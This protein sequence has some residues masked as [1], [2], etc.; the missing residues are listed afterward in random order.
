[1]QSQIQNHLLAL[2]ARNYSP[3]TVWNRRSS[4]GKF[5]VWSRAAGLREPAE[6][7]PDHLEAYRLSLFRAT[8][9]LGKLLGWGTQAEYL[10]AVKGFF[11]WCAERG[12]VTLDPAGSWFSRGAPFCCR[13]RC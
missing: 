11:G 8:T 13:E 12:L 3:A 10:G 5:L 6:L 2:A 4:L 7:T 9:R 1:M